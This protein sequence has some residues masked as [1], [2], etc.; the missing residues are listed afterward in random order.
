[1]SQ[2][3]SYI[4]SRALPK[5]VYHHPE[6]LQEAIRLLNELEGRCKIIAGCSDFIPAIRRGAWSFPDGFN[7]VD[8][9]GIRELSFVAEEGTRIRVGAATRLSDIIQSPLIQ[10]RAPVLAEAGKEMASM[11]IRNRAT[12]GGNLCMASPA[13]DAAPPLLVLDAAVR[14]KGID[15][16]ELIPLNKFFVGPGK[17]VLSSREIVTEVEF[18]GMNPDER[19]CW[20]KM[21]R[22]N[23][24]TLSIVSVATWAKIKGDTFSDLRIA[25]GAVAPTPIRAVEAEQYLIGK[26]T[27]EEVIRKGAEIAA[28]EIKP[29]SDVRA[30]AEYRRD[31]ANVLTKRALVSC[32]K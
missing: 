26:K 17:T 19:S 2:M 13:A 30:S 11:Q 16:E 29:I 5:F 21:G 18:P 7:L 12:V 31:M 4:G 8:L 22:R 6:D 15:R 20:I 28:G 32:L 14:V 9:N 1:M 27:S 24:F 10:K 3:K 23:S 25:L